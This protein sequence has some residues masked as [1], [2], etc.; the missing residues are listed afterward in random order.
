MEIKESISNPKKVTTKNKIKGQWNN[1]KIKIMK[2]NKI[3]N[4]IIFSR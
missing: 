4:T 1:K 2:K 3:N